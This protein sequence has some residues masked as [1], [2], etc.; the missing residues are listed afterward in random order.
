M[1]FYQSMTTQEH[2]PHLIQEDLDSFP[3]GVSADSC[4]LNGPD[5]GAILIRVQ[6]VFLDYGP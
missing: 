1:D 6:L 4:P 5:S 2:G 3:I